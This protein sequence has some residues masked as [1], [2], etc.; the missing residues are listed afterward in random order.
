MEIE[1]VTMIEFSL[2]L[3]SIG[4]IIIGIIKQVQNSKC[5]EINCLCFKC[6]R[7]SS[8]NNNQEEVDIENNNN[9]HNLNNNIDNNNP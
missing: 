5:S 4:V 8:F 6:K 2:F 3:S 7:D 1:N 9:L